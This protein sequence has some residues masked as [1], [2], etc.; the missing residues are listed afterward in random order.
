MY[1]Y[2]LICLSA[3]FAVTLA[4]PQAISQCRTIHHTDV[5]DSGTA[6]SNNNCLL[7]CSIHGKLWPHNLAEGLL[8]PGLTG[9]TNVCKEGQCVPGAPPIVLGYIDVELEAAQLSKKAMGLKN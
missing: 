8:C 3:L 5:D 7:M 2:Y 4:D 1:N 6:F 9:S